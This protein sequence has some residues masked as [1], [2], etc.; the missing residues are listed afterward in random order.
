MMLVIMTIVGVSATKLSTID[1]LVASNEQQK[2]MLLQETANKLANLSN[3]KNISKA[4]NNN[5]VFVGNITGHSNQF[6][7]TDSKD[8]AS[9]IITDTKRRVRCN[10][11]GRGTSIGL[12]DCRVFDFKVEMKKSHSSASDTQYQGV[13]KA[14]PSIKCKGCM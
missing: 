7:V 9:Q 11:S 6:K 5:S 10:R 2:M 4:L 14:V 12:I 3:T 13:G 8:G 1:I